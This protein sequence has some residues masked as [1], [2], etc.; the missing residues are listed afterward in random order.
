M[1]RVMAAALIALSI[2]SW[3]ERVT[4]QTDATNPQAPSATLVPENQDALEFY[5]R[6]TVAQTRT[7]GFRV[8]WSASVA[9]GV[10][11]KASIRAALTSDLIDHQ[12]YKSLLR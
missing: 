6:K 4:A 10:R 9:R 2:V 8:V 7:L 1:N 5:V 12:H 11:P 3:P